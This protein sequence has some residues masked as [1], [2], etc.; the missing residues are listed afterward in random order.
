MKKNLV[1]GAAA[2]YTWEILNPFV[3]SCR[4]YCPDAE[5]FFFVD[6]LSDFTRAQLIKNGVSIADFPDE[7][8][9][10][11]PNN[12]R[13]KI[14]AD[15]LDEHGDDYEQ[16]FITDTRDVIFQGDIFAGFKSY[17]NYLCYVTENDDIRG[18]KSGTKQNYDWIVGC[19]GK[20]EADKLL[21]KKIICSG[22]VLAT[23]DAIKI[24][25]RS[26][27]EILE[28]KT[29]DVFDQATMNYL[30]WDNRLP[31]E[32]LIESDVESGAILTLAL[33]T[34]FGFSGDKILHVSENCP[35][36]VHQYDRHEELIQFVDKI[37][38]DKNFQAD[39]RFNDMRSI[40]EQTS[41]LLYMDKIGA[42]TQL[43]M[44]KYLTNP[45]FKKHG[46]ELVRLLNAIL[47]KP[48]TQTLE[49]LSL[50]VQSAMTNLPTMNSKDFN[51]LNKLIKSKQPIE[52]EFKK[53]IKNFVQGAMWQ[54][55]DNDNM[56]EVFKF[57]DMLNALED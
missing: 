25:C 26:M 20:A 43:F 17:Q 47:K 29:A 18:S 14:F 55:F 40:I 48:P 32:N 46:K 56:S 35:A 54:A 28:H 22:T 2:N 53:Y 33:V 39:E 7:M 9:R 15:F 31:I 51:V 30:V 23:A 10:G 8:R 50:A 4:K 57:R 19:F 44:K 37:H 42:A 21:D 6:N 38:R 13:W 34:V 16:I 1:L 45:D 12:T 24:F 52:P 11:I 27:W 5:I 41:C 3:N 49:L 36:V